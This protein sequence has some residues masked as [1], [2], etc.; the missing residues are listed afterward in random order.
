M[1]T[2]IQSGLEQLHLPTEAA[3]RLAL[4]GKK[5][6]EQNQVMNLT[7]ITQPEQV[8][9]L[10]ML[11]CAA[12]AAQ[13]ELAG[14][15]VLDVGTGAGFPGMVL[16]CLEPTCSVTLLDSLEKRIHWLQTLAPQLGAEGVTC[17]HGRAEELGQDP[18]YREQFDVVTSRAVADLSLLLELCLP[19]VK[20]GGL[21]VAMKSVE[22]G[23]EVEAA[24][25]AVSILGGRLLPAVDYVI[26]GTDITHR[27]VRVEKVRPT[28]AKYPRRFA[29]MKKEPLDK[30][31]K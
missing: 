1:L 14:K 25:R 23:V 28:P 19:F 10:H 26:P 13:V 2:I 9:R 29:K 20:E 12:V 31:K 30:A 7:A 24:G 4:Y 5:L 15:R 11:D 21:F 8:A 16:Q 27:L 6:L 18:A 17:I 22:S 3:P